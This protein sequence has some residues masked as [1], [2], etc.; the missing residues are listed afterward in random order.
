MQVFL[1][2]RWRWLAAATFWHATVD[3]V[4]VFAAGVWGAYWAEALVAVLAAVSLGMAFALRERP[5]GAEE[6]EKAQAQ[7]PS[8]AR[9]PAWPEE[10]RPSLER[11]EDTRYGEG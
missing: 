2:G 1:R 8:P 7:Q 9:A 6:G 3:G 5:Q 4:V 11:L 10:S